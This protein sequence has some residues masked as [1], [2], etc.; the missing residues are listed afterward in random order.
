ML[1]LGQFGI[2]VENSVSSLQLGES[3]PSFQNISQ[4]TFS[5][6]FKKMS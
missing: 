6:V 4:T 5:D 1:S 2:Y 3:T